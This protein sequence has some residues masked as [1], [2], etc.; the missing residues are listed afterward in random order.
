MRGQSLPNSKGFAQQ[1]RTISGSRT[2][3]PLQPGRVPS[4][5]DAE[6]ESPG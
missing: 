2:P 3:S 5:T 6:L 1:I 4:P